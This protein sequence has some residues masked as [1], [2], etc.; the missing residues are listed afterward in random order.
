MLVKTYTY[1]NGTTTFEMH[2]QQLMYQQLKGR[3]PNKTTI[4]DI[5]AN[6]GTHA[7]HL[8]SN[9]FI[10]HAF[11]PLADNFNLLKC[12][13]VAN[14]LDNLI[15]NKFGLSNEDAMLCL[16]TAK[17]NRGH[18]VLGNN[19]CPKAEQVL[20]KKLDEYIDV[21]LKGESP[22]M[23]KID[24]EGHEMLEGPKCLKGIH[25]S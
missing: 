13:K 2:I 12:S 4:L 8:A 22:Y 9:G 24:V 19:E 18:A 1:S 20:V 5:G 3:V 7:L 14:H 25:P 23:I 10:V 11:E 6:I 16:N 21:T 15:L 17:N